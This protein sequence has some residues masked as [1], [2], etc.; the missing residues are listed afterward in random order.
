MCLILTPKYFAPRYHS[1]HSLSSFP[2]PWI[3]WTCRSS[4]P[5]D[6]SSHDLFGM[7]ICVEKWPPIYR[8]S[9]G[10]G[11]NNLL[12]NYFTNFHIKV[13]WLG[14]SMRVQKGCWRWIFAWV[15][16]HQQCFWIH[17]NHGKVEVKL[18]DLWQSYGRL[19][20][21][22]NCSAQRWLVVTAS[23]CWQHPSSNVKQTTVMCQFVSWHWHHE[24]V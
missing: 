12:K 18:E 19:H 2:C 22:W 16:N 1:H 10:H 15:K 5:G 9:K 24:D 20:D 8:G 17:L 13:Q 3:P 21:P 11:L 14:N 7:V 6:S 4:C 23:R